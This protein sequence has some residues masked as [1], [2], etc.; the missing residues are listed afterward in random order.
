MGGKC[1]VECVVYEATVSEVQSGK[2]ET[3]TGVTSR[4]FKRR[5]YEHNADMKKPESRT[6]SSLMNKEGR[7]RQGECWK[8]QRRRSQDGDV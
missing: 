2:K 1:Q 7:R 6:K 4:P 3:Y 8:Q 5:F